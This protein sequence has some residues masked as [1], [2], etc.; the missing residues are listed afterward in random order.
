MGVCMFVPLFRP[1]DFDKP[2]IALLIFQLIGFT[3][4]YNKYPESDRKT[5]IVFFLITIV[6]PMFGYASGQ[7]GLGMI[8]FVLGAAFYFIFIFV[9]LKA[10]VNRDK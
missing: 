4:S 6:L 9:Y 3:L 2:L 10:L 7:F 5:L 8:C 1:E